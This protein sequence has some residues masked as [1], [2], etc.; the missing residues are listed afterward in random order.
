MHTLRDKHYT[1]CCVQLIRTYKTISMAVTSLERIS[2]GTPWPRGICNF[3]GQIIVLGRGVHR[4][5][6]GPNQNNNDF[7]AGNLFEI[8][9][10]IAELVVPGQ[11]ASDEIKANFKI[12]AT[13]ISAIFDLWSSK[14]FHPFTQT[15]RP[16]AT[17]IFDQKSQNFYI[18]GYSGIDLLELPNFSKNAVD[19][20]LRYD[21]RTKKWYQVEKHIDT[22]EGGQ[23]DT[24]DTSN[25]PHKHKPTDSPPPHGW[26]AGPECLCTYNDKLY[27]GTLDN[28]IVVA[29]DLTEIIRDPNS[30]APLGKKVLDEN[31]Q[32]SGRSAKT[33][34]PSALAVR[35]GYLY[36]GYRTSSVITKFKLNSQG[37]PTTGELIADFSAV[38]DKVDIIDMVFDKSG[39]LYVSTASLGGIWKIAN[40]LSIPFIPTTPIPNAIDL[41]KLTG[42][43]KTKCS[44]IMID[45]SNQL[46]ICSNNH[47]SDISSPSIVGVVYRA[48][49]NSEETFT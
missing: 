27:V 21:I 18:C 35:N 1:Y 13:P 4:N 12:F 29:Y 32:I 20:V 11:L 39:N 49:L 41:R 42:N 5:Q 47:D 10:T 38:S 37:I 31:S 2:T 34:G 36:V 7:G 15:D 25:Y 43:T 3:N 48:N 14:G 8:D 46:Y 45:D 6:G 17:L 26:L 9:P 19:S 28:N 22:G 24:L 44:N 23:G 30:N 33:K 16:Y 40:N